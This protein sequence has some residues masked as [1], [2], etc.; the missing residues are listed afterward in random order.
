[1]EWMDPY[2]TFT[3]ECGSEAAELLEQFNVISKVN[4]GQFGVCVS[5]IREVDWEHLYKTLK[6]EL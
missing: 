1:M 2:L 5:L 3:Q 4:R 6:S